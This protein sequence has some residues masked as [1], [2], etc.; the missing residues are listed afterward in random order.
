MSPTKFKTNTTQKYLQLKFPNFSTSHPGKDTRELVW[1]VSVYWKSSLIFAVGINR[2]K[3]QKWTCFVDNLKSILFHLAIDFQTKQKEHFHADIQHNFLNSSTCQPSCDV[4][5]W[6]QLT[7]VH[8]RSLVCAIAFAAARHC[9]MFTITMLSFSTDL[10][11]WI[12]PLLVIFWLAQSA[13]LNANLLC[14]CYAT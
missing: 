10:N 12:I 3:L 5:K 6:A 1:L 9:I 7:N 4:T 11:A 2:S 14:S 13:S 8:Q